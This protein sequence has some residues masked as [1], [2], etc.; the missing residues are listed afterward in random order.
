MIGLGLPSQA[1]LGGRKGNQVKRDLSS[2]FA[3]GLP[4][5]K[6]STEPWVRVPTT[7]I[8]PSNPFGRLLASYRPPLS[9]TTNAVLD[10]LPHAPQPEMGYQ[11][12]LLERQLRPRGYSDSSIH[13]TFVAHANPH[14]RLV[15]PATL[16][17]S[18]EV[19]PAAAEARPIL[20]HSPA[21]DTQLKQQ[22][23]GLSTSI[24]R[25]PSVGRLRDKASSS[26]LRSSSSLIPHSRSTREIPP[27]PPLPISISIAPSRPTPINAAGFAPGVQASGSLRGSGS[28]L[29]NLSSWASKAAGLSPLAAAAEQEEQ[30]EAREEAGG[31]HGRKMLAERSGRDFG[32]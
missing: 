3:G 1:S 9:A 27:V 13:T 32:M 23:T 19:T 16:A 8:I 24:A 4:Q 6:P 29:G 11:P 2:I 18:S 25:K 30:G 14:H 7:R 31:E 26:Q 15:S 10:S 5:P 28:L 12:T 17:L 21:S 22:L 20:S